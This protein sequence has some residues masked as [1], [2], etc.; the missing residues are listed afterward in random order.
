[1][2]VFL[3]EQWLNCHVCRS[4]QKLEELNVGMDDLG[5]DVQ[6]LTQQCNGQAENGSTSAPSDTSLSQGDVVVCSTPQQ[7]GTG[8]GTGRGAPPISESPVHSPR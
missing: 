1:M 8:T 7:S 5:E 4:I 3:A 2:M 6:A